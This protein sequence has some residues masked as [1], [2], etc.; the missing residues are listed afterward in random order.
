MQAFQQML[1]A[2]LPTP[3]IQLC[4][5]AAAR[6]DRVQLSPPPPL[7][8]SAWTLTAAPRPHALEPHTHCPDEQW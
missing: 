5:A 7:A 8:L 3:C 6:G 4:R 1:K 2:T